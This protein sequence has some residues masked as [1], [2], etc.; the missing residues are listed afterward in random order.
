MSDEERRKAKRVGVV[1]EATWEGQTGR[2]EARV[3][4]ISRD[5]CYLDTI[6]EA[7]SGDA[8][9]ISVRLPDGNWVTLSG[10]VAHQLPNMGF[11]ISFKDLSDEQ[12]RMIDE[13]VENAP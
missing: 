12:R 7:S 4:D 5:G 6:G 8:V 1:L 9:R 13:M 11:G 10:V 3:S 2:Y